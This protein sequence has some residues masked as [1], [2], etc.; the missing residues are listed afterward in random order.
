MSAELLRRAAAKV[1]QEGTAPAA[2]GPSFDN[3][4]LLAVAD[5]LDRLADDREMDPYLPKHF[6]EAAATVARAY[7]NEQP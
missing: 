6:D 3:P 5:L 7:L 2:L 4:R 1:R